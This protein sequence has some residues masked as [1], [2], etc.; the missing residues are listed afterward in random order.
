[1]KCHEA[2]LALDEMET[3]SS[4]FLRAAYEKRRDWEK[5]IGLMKR[6]AV[7]L[8]EGPDRADKFLEIAKLAT[9]RIKK[10]DIC[11]E[12][13]K[14]VLEN[15][16][17]N[18]DALA[19]LSTLFERSKNWESLADVLQKQVEITYDDK[20]QQ[21]LYG[22][23]GQILGDRL[24]NDEGAAEAWR[25]LLTLNPS[26]R[27]AQ[28]Q[29][30]KK[31]LALGRWDDLEVFYSESGK[32]DEFI[33]VLESQEAKE[34][35]QE[36]KIGLLM[37]TAELWMTQKGK[38]DRAARA[39][40]KV[41][42]LDSSNLAA[43]E[44]LIP[45]YTTANN[46][47]GLAAAIEVKLGDEN[48][49]PFEKLELYREVAGLYETKLKDPG[50]AFERYLAA[51]EI[52]PGDEQCIIDVERAAGTTSG[53]D[54]LI[55]AYSRCIARA[56]GE[57][58]APL[59]IDLHLRLGR[60]LLDEVERTDDALEQFRAVY[61][62]D[63]EN[64]Q[65]IEALERLY[66]ETEKFTELLGIYEKKR[67]LS[68]DPDERKQILYAIAELYENQIKEPRSAIDTYRLVLD[69]EPM[70]PQALEA[71]D[72]LYLEQSEWEPYVEV[73]RARIELDVDESGL[74]DLK[75]RLGTTLEKHIGDA[76]GALENYRE[77]LFLDPSNDDARLA[78][79]ALLENEDL[80]AEAASI[81]QEIYEGRGDWEKLINALEILAGAEDDGERRVGL[82]RKVART[83]SENLS[84]M[85][86]ALDAQ[87]RA[88]KDDPS[89]P[90]TRME[91]EELA[92]RSDAWD[93]LDGI[94]SEIAESLSDALLA[95]EYWMRLAGI[96]E[97]LGKID[98]AASGYEH[99]LSIDAGDSEA[100]AAMDELYRRTERWSDLITVFRRRIDLAAEPEERESLY[101][102]MASVYEEKLGKPED[103]I[104]GLPR[105]AD[106]GRHQSSCTDRA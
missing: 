7:A 53:W 42:N 30:K 31:Y 70:D 21:Q 15:D 67:E 58:D 93:Q 56:E 90:E 61:E 24:G 50:R 17:E 84:D 88:L 27:K 20:L 28:E 16:A 4:D 6:E 3:A 2:I 48:Q 91:L 49:D 77:I 64:A 9:E 57:G 75:Y 97:R 83:A 43:A 94:F 63:G 12:L 102:Q 23:L 82:L 89:N 46:S 54:S 40:E 41:L 39:Y 52:S 99:V 79:E 29:L 55:E 105:G 106:I 87:A 51:F 74:I 76:A 10:P 33:R 47:K 37:K 98:E 69:D 11:I 100:L 78:L 73:L 103:A 32:W 26:D 96:H 66:R 72:R 60:V 18:P 86:R 35:D 44:S 68:A 36:V 65:A 59:S 13:W 85:A 71:L 45:I 38:P 101:S 25:K 80:R 81:L 8:P 95:R 14:Q 19:A 22:K 104:R 34:S 5:L 1:M 92:E 62:T